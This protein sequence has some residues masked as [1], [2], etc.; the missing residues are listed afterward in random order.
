MG[1]CAPS[2]FCLFRQ[3]L[4]LDVARD[5]EKGHGNEWVMQRQRQTEKKDGWT[6]TPVCG[7]RLAWHNQ[8]E[9]CSKDGC[10]QY[11]VCN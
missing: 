10:L 8:A 1:A 3:P 11:H 7:R 4:L 2:A 5:V 6:V 9:L